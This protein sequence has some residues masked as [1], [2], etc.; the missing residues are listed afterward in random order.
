MLVSVGRYESR[1]TRTEGTEQKERFQ[2]FR[3]TNQRRQAGKREQDWPRNTMDEARRRDQHSRA[4]TCGIALLHSGPKISLGSNQAQ[5]KMTAGLRWL[6]S[7]R[8]GGI[9]GLQAV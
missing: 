7:G 3:N 2:L 4:I 9:G 1:H 8:L 5:K 6:V